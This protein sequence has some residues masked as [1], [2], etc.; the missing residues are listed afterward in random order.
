MLRYWG[1]RFGYSDLKETASRSIV[2][3]C[4]KSSTV[5]DGVT[6][7]DDKWRR[8]ASCQTHGFFYV[9]LLS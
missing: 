2:F 3:E 6:G 8:S 5:A 4:G 7:P 9:A 1:R